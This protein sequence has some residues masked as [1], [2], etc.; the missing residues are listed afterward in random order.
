MLTEGDQLSW[1]I[2]F[3][4]KFRPMEY[5][6]YTDGLVIYELWY[7]TLKDKDKIYMYTLVPVEARHGNSTDPNDRKN[8]DF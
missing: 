4:L 1:W 6:R 3:R 2:R 8:Q 7:K 5:E